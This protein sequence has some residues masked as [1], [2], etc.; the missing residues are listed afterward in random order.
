MR[1][2]AAGPLGPSRHQV[3]CRTGCSAFRPST[4]RAASRPRRL[5]RR[6]HSRGPHRVAARRP[7]PFQCSSDDPF[8]SLEADEAMVAGSEVQ[9]GVESRTSSTLSTLGSGDSQTL[10]RPMSSATFDDLLPTPIRRP[11]AGRWDGLALRK[12][13]RPIRHIGDV[14]PGGCA[15]RNGTVRRARRSPV[16]ALAAT[17]CGTFGTPKLNVSPPPSVGR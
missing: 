12:L 15:E 14:P 1:R 2:S 4:R 8:R 13:L 16:P 3:G 5:R 17:E 9:V 6:R 11:G 10:T 7:P